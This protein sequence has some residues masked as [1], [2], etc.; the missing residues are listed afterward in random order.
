MS[1]FSEIAEV[2]VP[3]CLV[4]KL[5][6]VEPNGL[7]D[8]TLYIFYDRIKH[9]YVIRGR[10]RVTQKS[11]SCTYSFVCNHSKNLANFLKYIICSGNKVRETLYNYD[12]F[13][14]E[15]NEITYSFLNNCAH[16]D[17]ELSGYEEV[18][19][20]NIANRLQM[21]KNVYNNYN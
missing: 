5:E 11:M 6:E 16:L 19:L 13:P 9:V 1:V 17:Y 20:F 10:R 3:D 12:N 8:T 7:I 4:L 18:T 21:L 2:P 14:T 15:S